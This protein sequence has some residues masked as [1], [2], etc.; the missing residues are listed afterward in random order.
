MR[1]SA[2]LN[3]ICQPDRKAGP[4]AAYLIEPSPALPDQE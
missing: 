4:Q 1:G 2:T 3:G